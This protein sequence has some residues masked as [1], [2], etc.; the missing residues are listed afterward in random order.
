MEEKKKLD[1]NVPESISQGVYS[2]LAVISH[3]ANEFV[4]DFVSLMPGIEKGVVCS[5]VIVN[6]Q[7]AK[8]LMRALTE[9][10]NKYETQY[11]KIVDSQQ[12][13]FLPPIIDSGGMA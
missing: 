11:G 13:Q 7:N 8:R 4:L 9:N 3:S 2:N 6:P 1:I 5:R 12:G 10:V